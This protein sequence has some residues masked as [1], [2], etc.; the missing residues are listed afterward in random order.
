MAVWEMW[1]LTVNFD[2]IEAMLNS[3]LRALA[4]VIR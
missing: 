1:L 3:R 4:N 2:D